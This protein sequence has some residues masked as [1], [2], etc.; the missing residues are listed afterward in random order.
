MAVLQP[1][2][3]TWW[4]SK[5]LPQSRLMW[6]VDFHER[7][8]VSSM[9]IVWHNGAA[10]SHVTVEGRL[11][12][13][14]PED[15]PRY[16]TMETLTVQRCDTPLCVALHEHEFD[17]VRLSFNVTPHEQNATNTIAIDEV[18]V[19][20]PD[21]T[22]LRAPVRSVLR[23][24]EAWLQRAALAVPSHRALA[25]QCLL[26]LAMASGSAAAMLRCV[27]ALMQVG[28]RMPLCVTLHTRTW[29]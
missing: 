13:A 22:G 20:V 1:G 16:V 25:Q 3:A 19:M 9:R 4:A 17:G 12:G 5:D 29:C 24:L 6:A 15:A 27:N 14:K 11:N 7:T 23:E 28:A 2:D 18:Q 10:S 8:A 21:A 26:Q